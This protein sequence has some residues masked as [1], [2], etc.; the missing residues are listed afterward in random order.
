LGTVITH[1]GRPAPCHLG[2]AGLWLKRFL[3]QRFFDSK[4]HWLN[5][6]ILKRSILKRSIAKRSL[7][8]KSVVKR[9]MLKRLIVKKIHASTD[10][11]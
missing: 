1:P 10:P 6:S 8:K 9:S 2:S 5:R 11:R 3:L 4:D 7:V